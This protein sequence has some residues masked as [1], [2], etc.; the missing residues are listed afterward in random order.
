MTREEAIR[1]M[2][3]E[4][5]YIREVEGNDGG[6]LLIEAYDMAI[7]ALSQPIVAKHFDI[8]S[9]YIYCSPQIAENVKVVVR[10]KD[11]RWYDKGENEVDV[12][13]Y[14]MK[15]KHNVQETDYCSFG[16]LADKGGDADIPKNQSIMQ[17]S[18][19]DDGRTHGEWIE[20]E[21]DYDNIYWECS[22]CEDAF[23][24]EVGTPKDNNYNFCPN[25]GAKMYKGGDDK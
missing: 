13:E 24:L 22:N 25:C 5:S 9:G 4:R 6:R 7:E 16:E 11:C 21:D 8:Q 17:Q 2:I 19:H 10:C 14:C 23:V 1:W 12:W 20:V 15:S 18:R 3:V